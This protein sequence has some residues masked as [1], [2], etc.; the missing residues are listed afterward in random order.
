MLTK[1][2][3]N[4]NDTVRELKQT[5][6]KKQQEFNLKETTLTEQYKAE[7]EKI[8]V[9]IDELQHAFS[10]KDREAISLVHEKGQLINQLDKKQ[11]KI[12]EVQLELVKTIEKHKIQAEKATLKLKDFETEML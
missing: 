10:L 11:T 3:A 7:K 2:N 4:L 12:A 6:E 9:K 8:S 1:Q 5:V